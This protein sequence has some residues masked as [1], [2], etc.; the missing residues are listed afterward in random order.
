MPTIDIEKA[1][2]VFN[3]HGF[4]FQHNP[5]THWSEVTLVRKARTMF[6]N[7]NKREDRLILQTM[8]RVVE[9][10]AK[11][12]TDCRLACAAGGAQGPKCQGS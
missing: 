2:S 6:F 7:L 8:K 9:Q 12:C 4:W 3:G 1:R 10:R 11:P 5:A